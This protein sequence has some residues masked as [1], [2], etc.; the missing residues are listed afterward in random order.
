MLLEGSAVITANRK[1]QSRIEIQNVPFQSEP[2]PAL[3]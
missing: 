1:L 2:K 3:S